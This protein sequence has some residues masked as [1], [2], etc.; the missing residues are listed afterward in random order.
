MNKRAPIVAE[1]GRPET[2]E[3]TASRKAE[4]SKAYRSSQ[5][6]RGLIAALLATLAIVVV[7]V[8]AVPRGEPASERQVDMVGIA[9][10]VESSLD[11]P[12]LVPDL[13]DFWR[14]NAAGLTNGAPPVWDVTLAPASQKERGFVKLAQAFG[15]DSSW[16]PQRLN[17]IAPTDETTIGGLQWDVYALGDAGAK[18]NVTY[19]IG[20][21]A[22]D[23]YVLLYGSRS[24]E[25]TADLAETLVPQI[26]DLSE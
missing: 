8:L 5:T 15:V 20:T 16:A 3:E 2:P 6:V 25:S 7:I 13:G 24:A 17:G 23:D 4:F 18:Q 12:V 26:R 10:D 1:L 9:A 21:Q 11:T 14:V 22:G 19:A